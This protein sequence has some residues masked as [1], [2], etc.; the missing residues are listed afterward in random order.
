MRVS[1]LSPLLPLALLCCLTACQ[2][3]SDPDPDATPSADGG[4]GFADAQAS[5][6]ASSALT[7]AGSS[8]D[9]GPGN[10]GGI[11]F[12]DGGSGDGGFDPDAGSFIGEVCQDACAMIAQCLGESSPDCVGDC[13]AEL[14]V[15]CSAS[16]IDQID[17]CSSLACGDYE[18]C[19][20]SVP[21]IGEE[22]ACGDGVCGSGED[23][24]SCAQDCGTCTC[25]DGT[26]SPGECSS[27]ASDCPGGCTCGDVCSV[28][29]PQDLSC[30]S[31]QDIVCS[32]DSFCCEQEWDGICVGEAEDLCGK[33]CP[34]FCGD[35]VCDMGE[36]ENSCP[37]D[38]FIGPP[39]PQP[40]N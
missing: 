8:I 7:D 35:G 40:P 27:C 39:P 25:G 17:A 22:P 19:L 13:S 29:P 14:G 9:S 24:S 18:N 2:G 32:A 12:I 34:A 23:C 26:C 31:C 11:I 28:G 10:D 16:E 20:F 5:P 30:G 37:Q 38:C 15:Q 33:D 1:R 3:G 21:C 36:S 6:D 4:G